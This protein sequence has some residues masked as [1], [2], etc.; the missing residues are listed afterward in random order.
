M[1]GVISDFARQRVRDYAESHMDGLVTIVRGKRGVL[2]LN[3]GRVAGVAVDLVVYGSTALQA[4]AQQQQQQ[5]ADTMSVRVNLSGAPGATPTGFSTPG[6][7]ATA[8]TGGKAR[9]HKVTGQ[10]S[11]SNGPGEY[12]MRQLIVSIPWA[13]ALPRQDDIVLIRD[14]GVDTTLNGSVLRI[15][16]IEGG[17]AFGDARRLSCTLQGQSEY[18]TGAGAP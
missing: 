6:D 18:W 12:D 7:Q 8:D 4:V 9:I 5:Q 13:A 3:T 10:G 16:E 14:G 1:P 11:I 2:D 17:G 15:V